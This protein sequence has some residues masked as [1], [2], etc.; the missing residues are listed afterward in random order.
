MMGPRAPPW[1]FTR[2]WGPFPR[3][4]EWDLGQEPAARGRES[5]CLVAALKVMGY[6]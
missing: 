5:L 1:S 6:G 4:E 2:R 3:E